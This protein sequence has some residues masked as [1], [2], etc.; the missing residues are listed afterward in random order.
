M[1]VCKGRPDITV[2]AFPPSVEDLQ[3]E[4]F[5]LDVELSV[6]RPLELPGRERIDFSTTALVYKPDRVQPAVLAASL[7]GRSAPAPG[8]GPSADRR[9]RWNL[10]ESLFYPYFARGCALCWYPM[11]RSVYLPESPG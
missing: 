10:R 1:S 3:P 7:L 11:T 5:L 6:E 4:D 9:G 8:H 2:E